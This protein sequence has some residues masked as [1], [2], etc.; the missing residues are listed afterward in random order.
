M[1]NL[2]RAYYKKSCPKCSA[3]KGKLV[4]KDFPEA[5]GVSEKRIT[6]AR[7]EGVQSWCNDCRKKYVHPR[8]Q[9]TVHEIYNL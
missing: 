5:F 9:E 1:K 6:L 3:V 2:K 7:P 8:G 4:Y